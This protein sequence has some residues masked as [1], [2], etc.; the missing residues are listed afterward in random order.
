MQHWD[1]YRIFHF[2]PPNWGHF[3]LPELL[4][5]FTTP[6]T[7]QSCSVGIHTVS[8]LQIPKLRPFPHN[9][10]LGKVYP[11]P[12]FCSDQYH[13]AKTYP[14]K[15]SMCQKL[16]SLHTTRHL[17]VPKFSKAV[18]TPVYQ[19]DETRLRYTTARQHQ[20][21]QGYPEQHKDTSTTGGVRVSH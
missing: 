1:L 5:V 7:K 4:L 19:Q 14:Q 2:K 18:Q 3:P 15:H 17:S 11:P 6:L 13:I 8:S 20:T 9:V 16:P 21:A 10:S 12:I